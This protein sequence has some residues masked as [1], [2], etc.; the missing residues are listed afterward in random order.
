MGRLQ[1]DC[2]CAEV[3]SEPIK[4]TWIG[5]AL[6]TRLKETGEE[7]NGVEFQGNNDEQ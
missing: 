1:H 4:N 7:G 3:R 5:N 6:A 2:I